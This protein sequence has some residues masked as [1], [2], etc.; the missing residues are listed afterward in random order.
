MDKPTN[1][2]ETLKQTNVSGIINTTEDPM[3]PRLLKDDEIKDILYVVPMVK[4]ASVEV[5]AYNRESMLKSL[6]EQLKEIYVTPLGIQDIKDEVIRQFNEA[7]IK[8][9]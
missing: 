1:I 5:G 9:G 4:S 7:L 3:K 8:P 2:S 6:R